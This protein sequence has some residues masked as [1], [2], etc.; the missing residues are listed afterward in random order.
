LIKSAMLI[1]KSMIYSNI[2]GPDVGNITTI[3][4]L[5]V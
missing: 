1:S 2:E 5:T 3:N 4:R